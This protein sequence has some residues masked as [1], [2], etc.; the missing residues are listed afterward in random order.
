M[1]LFSDDFRTSDASIMDN[2]VVLYDIS[3]YQDIFPYEL[4][5]RKVF[6]HLLE[7]K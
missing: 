6:S 7:M 5:N 4:E 3:D 1:N 2:Q